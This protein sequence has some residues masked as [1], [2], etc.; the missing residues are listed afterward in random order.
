M[1][2]ERARLAEWLERNG[3]TTIRIEATNLD[4]SLLGK[5][6]S[7]AKFLASVDAGV[8]VTDFVFGAD[9]HNVPYMGFAWP[10]WRGNLLDVHLKPDLDTLVIWRPGMASVIA[11]FCLADGSPV[12]LCPRSLLKRHA[13]QLEE[14]GYSTLTAIEIEASVFEDSIH[15]ARGKGFQDLRPLGGG[16]GACYHLAKSTDWHD[17]MFAVTA[18]LD[19]VGIAWEAWNDEA[20]AGQIE[21]NLPPADPVIVADAWTRAR[22]IMREVAFEM[23]RSVTFMA[24]WCDAY[25]QASHLN[26]S[27]VRD[28]TNAFYAE[29]GPSQVMSSFIGGVMATLAGATSFALPWITSYRR[30]V[31]MQGPPTTLTWGVGN[32][33]AAIRALVGH[34][35]A[36]RLECRVPGSDSNVYLVL[37]VTLAVG[38]YGIANA[39]PAPPETTGL[40]WGATDR[41]ARIPDSITKAADA[42][43]NDGILRAVLGDE[44]VDYWVGTRRWEWWAFHT[45]GGDPDGPLSSWESVRYFELV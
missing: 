9:L 3:I 44:L 8:T 10:E 43:S 32:K 40:A 2:V 33:S 13:R 34:P 14:A 17:Y 29:D 12:S 19:E 7:P 4:G 5:F 26:I 45:G 39:L 36:S 28:E 41:T 21:L 20:A 22:Q 25:G 1:A 30:L 24:K 31:E 11:D 16:A 23:G 35:K 15:E 6:V 38:A 18:R 42:L 37:G 27:L